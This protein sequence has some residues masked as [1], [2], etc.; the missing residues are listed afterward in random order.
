MRGRGAWRD[1]VFVETIGS[2]ARLVSFRH[3]CIEI[4]LRRD[5][6]KSKPGIRFPRALTNRPGARSI[7]G[8][9]PTTSRLSNALQFMLCLYSLGTASI[10]HD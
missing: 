2:G 8:V 6:S 5:G 10:G 4:V 1:N 3:A 7:T 9:L